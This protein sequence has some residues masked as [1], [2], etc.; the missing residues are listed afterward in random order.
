MN[1]SKESVQRPVARHNEQ[2]KELECLLFYFCI[3]ECFTV[4]VLLFTTGYQ[5]LRVYK[6]G[7]GLWLLVVKVNVDT[8]LIHR[9]Q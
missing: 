8:S 3:C 9:L 1:S 5:C 7:S 4:V 6:T 2:F